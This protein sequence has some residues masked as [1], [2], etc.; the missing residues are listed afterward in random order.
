MGRPGASIR[1][2]I[3]SAHHRR[4]S[5]QERLGLEATATPRTRPGRIGRAVEGI[6][7]DQPLHRLRRLLRPDHL[8][9]PGVAKYL[10]GNKNEPVLQ[11][12]AEDRNAMHAAL[13]VITETF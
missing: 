6:A 1:G 2:E 10:A 5:H 4:Y 7:V 8:L 13:R 3:Q 11:T 9:S 12:V